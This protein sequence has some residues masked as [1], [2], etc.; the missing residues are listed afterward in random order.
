MIHRWPQRRMNQCAQCAHWS[1]TAFHGTYEMRGC[2][3]GSVMLGAIR[4]R[5]SYLILEPSRRVVLDAQLAGRR[6]CDLR[7]RRV[8]RANRLGKVVELLPPL[9]P[10]QGFVVPAVMGPEEARAI[11][12]DTVVPDEKEV[13]H[14]CHERYA[15]VSVSKPGTQLRNAIGVSFERL[16]DCEAGMLDERIFPANLDGLVR[17]RHGAHA[18][19]CAR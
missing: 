11:R 10:E 14:T 2:A 1:D 4:R 15:A 5:I 18:S 16:N 13:I 19:R 12:D 7:P 6:P 17:Y 3:A 8:M 9:G